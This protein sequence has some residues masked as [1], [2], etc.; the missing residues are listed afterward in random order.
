MAVFFLALAFCLG[1]VSPTLA[2]IY[3]WSAPVS[4]NGLSA[5]QILT[6]P[7]GTIVGA[8]GFGN[9]APVTVTLAGNYAPVV[10]G[11]YKDPTVAS[12]MAPSATTLGTGTY[13]AATSNTTGNASLNS[14]FNSF[15]SGNSAF[16]IK[17]INLTAGATYSVQL[18]SVDDRASGSAQANFQDPADGA[19]VSSTIT[20]SGNSYIVGTFTVPSGATSVTLQENLPGGA[21]AINALVVRAVS[22]T[23]AINF[24]LQPTDQSLNVGD[25]ATFSAMATG[26]SPL[27]PQWE[28]GPAG[29]PYTNLTDGG[30]I[31]GSQTYNL[32]ITNVNSSDASQQ[33]VLTLSNGTTTVSSRA[34]NLSVFGSSGGYRASLVPGNN[35]NSAIIQCYNSGGG[36]V[37]LGPGVY[38]GGINMYPNVTLKGSGMG[39]TTIVGTITQGYY[40]ANMSMQDLTVSGGVSASAFSQGQSPG[41]GIFFV[42]MRI[43]ATT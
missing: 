40:G 17:L 23:P 12:I 33:Y 35:V 25:T 18:F 28:S 27:A 14:V 19:D 37:T 6:A 38:Y 29:G 15:A 5:N 36:I 41:A 4:M 20:E 10:F 3:T 32:T 26:P 43:I 34:A 8:V 31:S 42:P 11:T 22:F 21:G 16:T 30:R 39:V 1:S 13:P 2:G 24:T 9:T 7:A